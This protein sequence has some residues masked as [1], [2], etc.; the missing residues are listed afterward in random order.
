MKI[1]AALLLLVCGAC[2]ASAAELT[3]STPGSGPAQT[4]T[5]TA[6]PTPP[7]TMGPALPHALARPYAETDASHLRAVRTPPCHSSVGSFS[8][9]Q[10]ADGR[11]V[12]RRTFDRPAQGMRVE[13]PPHEVAWG[14]WDGTQLVLRGEQDE[15][16]FHKHENA[17]VSYVLR[18][19]AKI[20][21]LI[22]TRNGAPIRLAPLELRERDCGNQKPPPVPDVRE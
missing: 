3:V 9:T 6:T 19:E 12:M 17:P 22:G 10:S 14:T 21:Q 18:W 16:G 15:G 11:V 1:A 20:F 2:A 5:A 13:R 8:F 4:P 7:T